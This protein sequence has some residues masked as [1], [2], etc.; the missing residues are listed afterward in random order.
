MRGVPGRD[1][2]FCVLCVLFL[3]VCTI[4]G[5]DIYVCFTSR[6][7]CYLI[8]IIIICVCKSL[9]F[10]ACGGRW[11]VSGNSADKAVPVGCTCRIYGSNT[12]SWFE[13]RYEL[14]Q[15]MVSSIGYLG[16]EQQLAWHRTC[17]VQS[18]LLVLWCELGMA[19]IGAIEVCCFRCITAKPLLSLTDGYCFCL[20][21]YLI[22]LH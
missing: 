1:C 15:D 8:W 9:L 18:I 11:V 3:Y 7:F 21:V 20:G 17:R 5:F 10:F 16:H 2:I 6:Q 13:A 22:N 14:Y 12:Y 19:Y 4:F